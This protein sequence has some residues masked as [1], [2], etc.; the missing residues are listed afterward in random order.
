MGTPTRLTLLSLACL[1][2]GAGCNWTKFDD[3]SADAP[4][5]SIS[6]PSGFDSH[7]FGKSI[8]PLSTG[9]GSAAAFVATSLNGMHVALVKLD[10]GGGVKTAAVSDSALVAADSSAITSVAEIPGGVPTSL[11]LGSPRVRDQDFGRVYTY[12]PP[13]PA[14]SGMDDTAKTLLITDLGSNDAGEGRGLAAGYLDGLADTADYVIGSDNEVAVVVDGVPANTALGTVT[15]GVAPLACDV[16]YDALQDS[17]FGVRRPLLTARLWA[18][19]RGPAVQ[20]L[21][22]GAPRA[23]GM[24]TLSILNVAN[25]TLG[26]LASV[27]G[28][29][30][31]FGHALAAGDANGDGVNDF[32]VVGAPGQQAFVYQGWDSLVAPALP[33]ALA[34]T[35]AAPAGVDFGFAVAALNVDGLPGDEVLVSDPR[36][37]V[38]GKTGAGHVLIYKFDPASNAM[39]QVGEIA[40]HSPDTD[41]NFGYTVNVLNFCRDDAAVAAG[42]A[43][44]QG[45]LSR[46]L[47]VGAANEVFVYFR[48]GELGQTVADVRT[49]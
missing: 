18:D 23:T 17:R 10:S 39:I 11:L 49:H 30:P 25:G 48:V 3:Q 32:L 20:Q 42:A 35:P 45:E 36:A 31:E 1:S 16:T 27:T 43:C 21:F 44:P 24:G 33:P 6:A 13:D 38:G 19:P 34:I 47:L 14:N 9:R 12:T 46:I 2:A 29:K 22:V 15:V 37:S 41:E 7:D 40:D 5:R 28:A 26:C 8:T 4:V